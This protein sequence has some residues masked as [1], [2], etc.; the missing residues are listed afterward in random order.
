MLGFNG[1]VVKLKGIVMKKLFD[2]YMDM[3]KVPMN[4]LIFC[5]VIIWTVLCGVICSPAI[6]LYVAAWCMILG[7]F[8]GAIQYTEYRYQV[9]K[10]RKVFLAGLKADLG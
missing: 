6:I 4:V 10:D 8:L 9:K 2:W 7:P 1:K 5:G 3:N